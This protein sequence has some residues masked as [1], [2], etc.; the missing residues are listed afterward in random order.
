MKNYWILTRLMLKNMAASMN[1]F[2]GIYEDGQKKQKAIFRML[3][4]AALALFGIGSVIYLE[5]QLFNF[6]GSMGEQLNAG[7]KAAGMQAQFDDPMKLIPGLAIMACML[8]TLVMGL[9]QGL[10]ELYQGKDAPFLAVL[11][12]SSRQIYGARITSLYVSEL[13]VN[14]LLMGPAFILYAIK[15]GSVLPV[16]LTAI[17][18]FLL[19]P[20]IPLA[21]VAL[22]SALLMRVSVISKHR[23]SITMI[24]SLAL[25]MAYSIGIS[26][27]NGSSDGTQSSAMLQ[28]IME[29][30]GL[31]NSVLRAFPPAQWALRGLMGDIPQLLLLFGVSAAATLPV[32][33]LIGPGYL[34]QALSTTERTVVAHGSRNAGRMASHSVLRTLHSLEWKMLLRTPSWLFNGLAGV[35]IFP[36]V[37][38]FGIFS[39]LS[40]SPEGLDY[41][42]AQLAGVHPAYIIVF[43][44]ALLGFGSMVN[45][46]VSTAVSREGGSWPFALALPVRQADR[47]MAK[48]LV[49]SEINLLCSLLIGI[50]S[51]VIMGIPVQHV[52]AALAL[53]MLVDWAA[54]A[55]SLWIDATHPHFKWTNEMEA[56][57]KNFN[58]VI[59][60]VV[61]VVC[62]A[63]CVVVGIFSWRLGPDGFCACVMGMALAE[64]L[65]TSWMVFAAAEKTAVLA[66]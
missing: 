41:I 12:L 48:L 17:P 64:A 11:P 62:V 1:P 23:E 33:F 28:S 42:R 3:G 27:F 20:L 13:L 40:R 46:V 43:G 65:F 5:I 52:A 25:A 45:P 8:I 9:F 54:A 30:N 58:Q 63:L 2:T 34:D 19:V 10:S 4:I 44:A 37:M 16:A 18:V 57:K 15:S 7:F 38:G 35:L 6:A 56:I 66:E 21:A 49:G 36:I 47:F 55:G 59:G 26:V 53:A 51:A 31:V 14:L 22:L 61:W 32:I 50:V 24:L 29:P 39:G 60:M